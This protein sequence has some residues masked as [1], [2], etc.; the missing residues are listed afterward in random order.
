MARP[1]QLAQTFELA[2]DFDER[3]AALGLT[4]LQLCKCVGLTA[5]TCLRLQRLRSVSR[6]TALLIASGF[7]LAHGAMHPHTALRSLFVARP[8]VVME[9][10]PCG[11]TYRRRDTPQSGDATLG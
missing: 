8:R 7:A 9:P 4:T 3:L 5:S 11:R 2:P 1:Y 6:K 10:N